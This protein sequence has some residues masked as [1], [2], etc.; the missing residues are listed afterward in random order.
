MKYKIIK[1]DL[2]Y[3]MNNKIKRKKINK[4]DYVYILL[5]IN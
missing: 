5:N 3:N 2:N 1:E 4:I